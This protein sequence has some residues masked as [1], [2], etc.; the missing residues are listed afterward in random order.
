M[1]D[2][3]IPNGGTT[4]DQTPELRIA[5]N[6]PLWDGS[7]IHVFRNGVDVGIATERSPLEY[8]F[9]DNI[10]DGEY[11]YTVEVVFGTANVGSSDYN[12]NVVTPPVPLPMPLIT[13]IYETIPDE[14]F[15]LMEDASPVLH[16]ILG[17]LLTEVQGIPAE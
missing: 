6:A 12:I 7:S 2:T 3:V 9:T 4:D 5:L 11:A 14:S 13:G 1:T 8:T 10:V 15:I 17:A 16:E